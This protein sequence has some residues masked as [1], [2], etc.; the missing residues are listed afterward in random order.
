MSPAPHTRN[1]EWVLGRIGGAPVVVAPTS[2]L[3]GLLVAASWFPLLSAVL[4]P[5]GLGVILLAS[6]VTLVGILLSI[7]V[8]E[9]AH[10]MVGT[11]LGRRPVRYELY[12]WGGRTTFGPAQGWRPWKDVLTCLAG[13]A[14]NLGLWAV[15]SAVVDQPVLPVWLAFGLWVVCRLNLVLAIFNVLPALPLDGGL[16]LA[17]GIEQIS[18][19]A[20]L[21]RKVAAWSGLAVLAGIIWWWVV[22]PMLVEGRRPAALTLML[23]VLVAWPIASACWREAGRGRAARSAAGLDL[24]RLLRPVATVG[25]AAPIAEVR[26]RLND[27]AGVILVVDGA[28]LLGS[29]DLPGLAELGDLDED[30]ATASQVCTAIP[31]SAV[32]S[33]ISGQDAVQALRRARAVSRWLIVIEAGAVRG[34][35]PTGAR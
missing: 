24:R 7:G 34:A 30:R 29:I 2:A 11:L 23:V 13:S 14:A 5:Y 31:A 21:G 1:D 33:R 22:G 27:G 25:A 6:A 4:E 9:L 17:A 19:R 26:D 32:T 3:L 20:G 15:G 8:H 18:G 28:E 10:G 35:V 16:A 12:L